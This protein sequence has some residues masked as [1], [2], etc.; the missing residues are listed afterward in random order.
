MI[1]DAHAHLWSKPKDLDKVAESG[2]IEQ[3]WLMHISYYRAS[4]LKDLASEQEMLE[5][6]RRYPGFFIPFG[7]IDFTKGP[8][9]IDRM[10]DAGFVG[11]KAIRPPKPYD[12]PSFLPIYERAEANRMP[13]LFHVGIILKNTREEMTPAQSLGPT[14]MR[15]S[16]LDG[17]AAAFPKLPLIAGHM[18]LPWINELFEALYYYPKIYCALCGYVDYRWLMDNLDRRP[19][20]GVEGETFCDRMMFATDYVYGREPH[21]LETL[22]FGQFMR[23]FFTHAG[24][25]YQWG[26]RIEF[27]LHQNARKILPA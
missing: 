12:D 19:Q 25:S 7:E 27:I 8:E 5:V 18:G 6:A 17:I 9:Q 4:S 26:A 23:D 21:L 20:A 3:V 13:V 10:K 15:P 16:M 22:R 2:G 1:I 24:R 14:N 11:L